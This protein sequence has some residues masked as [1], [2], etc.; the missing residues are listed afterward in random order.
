MLAL[1]AA[2]KPTPAAANYVVAV[3]GKAFTLCEVWGWRPQKSNPCHLFPKYKLQGRTLILTPAHIGAL[4]RAIDKLLGAGRISPSMAALVRVW[5]I[6]GCRNA[7]LRLAKREWAD[8]DAGVLRLPD[9]KTGQRAIPLPAAAVSILKALPAGVWLFPGTIDGKPIG[10]P[11]RP[12]N[13]LCQEAG[14]PPEATPHTLRHT[15]GSLGH[16]AG[17]SQKQIADQLG[18]SQLSTTELYIHGVAAEA[19]QAAEKIAGVVTAAWATPP[20]A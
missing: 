18:H 5:M 17:L 2:M 8:L 19:A 1:H 16:H 11:W 4:D 3:L 20:K 9:S 6:T 13:L 15:V 7:E 12:W 10:N 14:V